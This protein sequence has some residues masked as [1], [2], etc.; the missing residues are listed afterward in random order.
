MQS[1]AT[2]SLSE[3]TS[4]FYFMRDYMVFTRSDPRRGCNKGAS[5]WFGWIQYYL[6][7]QE[8][9]LLMP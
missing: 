6:V 4:F 1:S 7:I 9:N 8:V 3:L 2:Q 5:T